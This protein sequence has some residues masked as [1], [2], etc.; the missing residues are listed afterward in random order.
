[1][2]VALSQSTI[3]GDASICAVIWALK[4]QNAFKLIRVPHTPTRM[5]KG[6]DAWRMRNTMCPTSVVF[7]MREFANA[8]TLH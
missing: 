2:A 4:L 3:R 1:V 7:Q 5:P 6:C 8:W